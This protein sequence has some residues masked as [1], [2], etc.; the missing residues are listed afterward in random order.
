MKSKGRRKSTKSPK[1][2]QEMKRIAESQKVY[3]KDITD[4]YDPKEFFGKR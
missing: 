1:L 4:Y 2:R 3:K